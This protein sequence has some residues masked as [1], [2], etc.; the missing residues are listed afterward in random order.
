[1]KCPHCGGRAKVLYRYERIGKR[2]GM[3]PGFIRQYECVECHTRFKT[4]ELMLSMLED[5][6]LNFDAHRL[7]WS[8]ERARLLDE[9]RVLKLPENSGFSKIRRLR[10]KVFELLR[11]LS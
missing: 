2:Y 4:Y 8:R 5:Q 7:R 1:M 6:K 10:E 3:L 9:L 11:E